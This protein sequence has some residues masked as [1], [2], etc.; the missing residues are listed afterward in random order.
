MG[1]RIRSGKK[2]SIAIFAAG[3]FW[4]KEYAFNRQ[5]GV[6]ATRVGYTGGHTDNPT[7]QEVCS[8]ISGHAEAVEITFDPEV[9]DFETL[10]KYFFEIHDPS[11][12]RRA[13]GGQYRSAIFYTDEEQLRI[14]K[15]LVEQLEEKGIKVA[16]SL[17]QANTFWPAEARHQKYCDTKGLEPTDRYTKRFE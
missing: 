1:K 12:D 3:C 9:T 15:V 5:P 8:K 13:K 10:A 4:S 17:E 2:K 7:Y 14:A 16:T 11:I 6:L